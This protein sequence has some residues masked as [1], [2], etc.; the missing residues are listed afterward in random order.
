VVEAV[1]A[2]LPRVPARPERAWLPQEVPPPVVR[3]GRWAL[4]VTPRV[5]APAPRVLLAMLVFQPERRP[6]ERRP[7]CR[8]LF[9][10][11]VI[12]WSMPDAL[13]TARARRAP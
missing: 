11:P 10:D 6:P 13:R 4:A 2:P 3:T 7:R 1:A 5:S 9:Q 12:A 8:P